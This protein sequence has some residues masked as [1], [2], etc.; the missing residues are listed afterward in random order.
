MADYQLT[1]TT[2]VIR[3]SDG[4]CIPNDPGN[5]DWIEYQDW[6]VAGN[7]PDPY[8]PPPAPI[9]DITRRQFYQR[10]AVQGVITE[11]EAKA[12]ISGSTLPASLQ[13]LVA[14]LPADQQFNAECLLLGA[15][16]LQRSHPMTDAIGTAYGWTSEQI[17]AFFIAAGTLL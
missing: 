17:D 14:A 11:T 6:I 15:Q 4:A 1:D 10:L 9:L 8:I 5:R 12:G 2:S 16:T 13:T 3:T 7:T